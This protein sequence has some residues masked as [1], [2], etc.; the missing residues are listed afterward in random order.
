MS[1]TVTWLDNPAA[2]LF[3]LW[4]DPNIREAVVSASRK[5][6]SALELSPND[7][8]EFRSDNIR[9]LFELPLAV[10]YRV[11][12]STRTVEVGRVWYFQKRS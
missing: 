6:D 7:V 8:G 9:I 10:S 11:D 4:S 3:E 1:Y 12:T 5:I 2:E